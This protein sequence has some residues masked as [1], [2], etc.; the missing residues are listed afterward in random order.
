MLSLDVNLLSKSAGMGIVLIPSL[1]HSL[2]HTDLKKKQIEKKIEKKEMTSSK[3]DQNPCADGGIKG[4]CSNRSCKAEPPNEC[5]EKKTRRN[6]EMAKN[7][8]SIQDPFVLSEERRC[9]VYV[10]MLTLPC[11]T[12]IPCLSNG[13]HTKEEFVI[14]KYQASRYH[15]GG[16]HS[17]KVKK[18][19]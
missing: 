6:F 7:P 13:V 17:S 10:H 16:S 5:F 11:R 4:Y 15:A 12:V 19:R 3:R 2:N 1:T 9:P 14:W 8:D 18:K